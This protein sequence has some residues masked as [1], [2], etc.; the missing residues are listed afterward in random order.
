VGVPF[1]V[2]ASCVAASLLCGCASGTH[3]SPTDPGQLRNQAATSVAQSGPRLFD[4]TPGSA[5]TPEPPDFHALPGADAHLGVLGDAAYRI[6]V[7]DDWNGDLLLWAHGVHG[8]GREV[9]AESPP[10]ALRGV[11]IQQGYAWAASSFSETGYEPGIGA[12]DTLL[13]KHHFA[14]QFG[15]PR[16]TYI[17]GASMGGQITVL[18][19]ENFPEEYDGGLSLCGAVAGQEELDYLLAWAMAAAFMAGVEPPLGQG[20]AHG[21]A[22]LETAILPQLDPRGGMS[23]DQA[24]AFESVIRNLTGGPRPFFRE[25]FR[26]HFA[27]NFGFFSGDPDRTLAWA[28]AAT[29]EA[30]DYRA[31]PGMG[32]EGD[33]LNRSV[34]RIAADPSLRDAAAHPETAPTT[35]RISDPLLSLHESGDLIVPISAEQSYRKKVTAAGSGELLVQRVIRAGTHCEFSDAELTRAWNDFAGW[36][37]NGDKPGGDHV[38]GDLSDTGRAFTEPLRPGDPGGR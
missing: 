28:R 30:A 34:P 18:S 37:R 14:R 32:F 9:E 26:R 4:A 10:A 24:R 20:R 21:T 36:V 6:E 7:P 33:V 31:D 22:V 38:L 2:L 27:S 8:F 15:Q 19:L 35:G 12:N 16:R 23:T 11:L 17:A 29:N 13:L 3:D 5:V 1:R 25:G